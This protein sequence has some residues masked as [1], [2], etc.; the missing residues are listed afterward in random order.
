MI[1]IFVDSGSSIRPEEKEKYGVEILPLKIFIGEK[2]FDD[3]EDLKSDDFYKYL[4]QDGIFPKTSLPSLGEA[5]K[6][7]KKCLAEGDQVI[8]ISISSGISG[9]Y[10]ALKMLFEN[11][12]D[13]RVIDSL[14]GAGGIKLLINEAN[15]HLSESLDDVVK[16]IEELIPRIRV[17]VV[18]ETLEYL[19]RG[20]R[21]SRTAMTV[22]SL[23]QLK[24]VLTLGG[25]DGKVKALGK[26][27]GLNKAIQK[28]ADTL[29]SE[30]CDPAFGIFPIYT[31]NKDNADAVIARTNEK[32]R[33]HIIDYDHVAHAIACHLGPNAFGYIFVVKK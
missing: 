3:G 10:S 15:K 12:P 8:I 7:V 9:T 14:T 19:H 25:E 20:G 29:E 21:L 1:K 30:N 18:P 32:F 17:I 6:R 16:H 2:E 27:R 24:P 23:L 28:V 4:I 5:E 31:Y 11:E 22:G 26:E 13:V 33:D